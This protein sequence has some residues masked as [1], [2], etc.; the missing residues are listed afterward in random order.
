MQEANTSPDDFS[1]EKGKDHGFQAL[2]RLRQLGFKPGVTVF[3]AV[4]YDATDSGVTARIVPFFRGVKD[5]LNSSRQHYVVGIYDT[6]NVCAR[7]I[8]EDLASEG[9][10]A[11]MSWEWS[12]NLGFALPQAWSYDQIQ[13]LTLTGSGASVEIDK[14]IQSSRAQP[15]GPSDVLPTPLSPSGGFDEDYFWFLTEQCVLAEMAENVSTFAAGMANDYVLHRIQKEFYWNQRLQPGG[16]PSSD[17][18]WN[19]YTPLG[20]YMPGVSQPVAQGRSLERGQYESTASSAPTSSL[21]RMSHWAA[22][23][24]G[25]LAYGAPQAS[26]DAQFGDLGAWGWIS[27]RF[28][29]TSATSL[30]RAIQELCG[31]S[32]RVGLVARTLVPSGMKTCW[33]TLTPTFARTVSSDTSIARC[34]ISCAR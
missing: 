24:R 19:A 21:S 4:D 14:N 28:G 17:A 26:G 8:A 34:R 15:A 23:T 30:G 3:F 25:Y 31:V 6:R 27:P 16:S 18:L 13:T 2:R 29:S 33:P 7:V 12:G 5:V 1:Y 22:S 20:E 9:F 11:G 10:I 32:S